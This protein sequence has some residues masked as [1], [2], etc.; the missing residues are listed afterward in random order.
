MSDYT[1]TNKPA[2]GS[3][4]VS[5]VLRDEFTLI[6]EAVNSKSDKLAR[7]SVSATAMTIGLG[8]Q[9]FVVEPDKDFGP[10]EVVFISSSTSAS[11]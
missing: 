5:K 6:Q 7:T 8:P 3:W 9:S 11:N 10:G 2:N 4:N 1:V